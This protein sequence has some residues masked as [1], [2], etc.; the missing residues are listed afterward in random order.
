M[1]KGTIAENRKV[2]RENQF[3]NAKTAVYICRKIN[4]NEIKLCN[5]KITP[6]QQNAVSVNWQS[7]DI[8]FIMQ[9]TCQN[10]ISGG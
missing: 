7:Y 3:G 4:N 6:I 1:K 9:Q 10:K 8:V 2:L 5:N